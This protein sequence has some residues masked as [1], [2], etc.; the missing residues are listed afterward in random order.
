MDSETFSAAPSGAKA[1]RLGAYYTPE[2]VVEFMIRWAIQDAHYKIIDPSFGNGQF[3]RA[4]ARQTKV[5][6]LNPSEQI[7]GIELDSDTFNANKPLL[8]SQFKIHKLENQDFFA[9][10]SFFLSEFNKVSPLEEFEAV[11]GNPPFIR[12]QRFKGKARELALKRAAEHGISLPGHASS[13][14]PFLIHAISL[15]KNGGRI[16]MIIPVELSYATYAKDILAY[17]LDQFKNLSLLSFQK[18]LFPKLAEDTYILLGENRGL[19]CSKFQLVDVQNEERLSHFDGQLDSVGEVK[20]L[21]REACSNL[22]SHKV[23]LLEFSLNRACRNLYQSFRERAQT[24]DFSVTFLGEVMD[25][26]IGYV[27][28]DNA[29]FHP[30]QATI[31][32]FGIEQEFLTPCLRRSNNL[33]GLYYSK[34]DW[35]NS[36]E[37]QKWLLHI[38]QT[39]DINALPKGLRKYLNWGLKSGILK[40]YKVK[41]RSPWYA[42]SNIK[43][44]DAFLTYMSHDAPR[45]VQNVSG[46]PAPNTLHVASL[47]K[48]GQDALDCKLLLIAWYTSLCFLSSEIE[49]HSL[50]AGMLKL[51]PNEARNIIVVI[52]RHLSQEEIED[53]YSRIDVALRKNNLEL[54]LNLGDES[55]LCHGLGLS[56]ETCLTLRE[57]YYKLRDRR[58]YR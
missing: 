26:G 10:D 16:A 27:S 44:G 31:E 14:A 24:A 37:P 47:K 9:A 43:I 23:K 22:K 13:W 5:K 1:K 28:G 25:I 50:G 21:N 34:E 19:P 2:P 56:Q 39:L 52:P 35:E 7:Y 49:G 17:L 36:L 40:R 58:K 33:R 20:T 48:S 53:T 6:L 42:L 57:A 55:I 30:D 45:L 18:R 12:Y 29:F 54:A 51:E 41:K 15:I 8:E 32:A 3:L 38:D 46:L 11:V 4:S